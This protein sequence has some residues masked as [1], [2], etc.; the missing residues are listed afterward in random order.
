M[1]I[2]K[3][4]FP[5]MAR[6]GQLHATPLV[7]FW[8]DVGQPKDFLTGSALYL[9]S[10]RKKNP[11]ALSSGPLFKGNVLVDPTATIG[12]GCK[13]GPNVV[14]GPNVTI[15]AGVRLNNT[16]VMGGASVK[17]YAWVNES[18]IGWHSSVG[19]WTRIDA[20]TVLG[21]DVHVKDEVFTNGATV[22]PHKVHCI[23]VERWSK[24]LDP[25]N[26]DVIKSRFSFT[27]IL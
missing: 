9:E 13:I 21:E 3:D 20:T 5:F 22:L 24:Y 1:S 26:C 12:Q 23:N 27:F 14:I 4:V 17:E 8:A 11:T 2:E 15:A 7:G 16:V 19:R 10:V 25:S 18:I 6:D